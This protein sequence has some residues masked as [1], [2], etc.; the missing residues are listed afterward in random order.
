M[1]S[2]SPLIRLDYEDFI[3]RCH[4]DMFPS[5]YEP[6]GT[7]PAECIVMGIPCVTS[8]LSGY[9]GFMEE[10][11]ETVKHLLV[12]IYNIFLMESILMKIFFLF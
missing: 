8:N 4:L 6:W 10:I 5:Y 12:T 3:R 1:S 7:S 9:G 2:G 11:L